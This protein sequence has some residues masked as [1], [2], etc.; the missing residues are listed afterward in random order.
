[1]RQISRRLI[2]RRWFPFETARANCFQIAICGRDERAQFGRRLL[3]R[4]LDHGQRVLAQKWRSASEQI[5]KHRTET[6][7]ISGGSKIG[8]CAFGLLRRDISGCAKDSQ[9]PCQV[10]RSVEPLGQS[11]I[12]DEGFA[13]TVQQNVP[14]FQIAMKD[15]LPVRVF[16]G[17]AYFRQ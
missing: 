2:T 13:A 3:R 11:E 12:A 8:S 4:L 17:P 1:M 9:R 10:G 7:N 16:C 14:R 6:V 5:E 15:S